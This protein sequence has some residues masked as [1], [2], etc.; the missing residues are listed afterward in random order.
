MNINIR[1]N[2]KGVFMKVIVKVFVF[3]F[4]LFFSSNLYAQEKLQTNAGIV[5]FYDSELFQWNYNIWNG[6]TLNYKNQNY[7]TLFG[8]PDAMKD[9][10]SLYDDAYKEYNIYNKKMIAGNIM[11]FCGLIAAL[12]GITYSIVGVNND[13]FNYNSAG[14]WIFWGGFTVELIG[15]LIRDDSTENLFNAARIFN[16][17]K[18]SEY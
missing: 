9:A 16:R 3:A 11:T 2:S 1:H 12:G 7:G 17:H 10:F 14:I 13:P 6:L 8:I 4:V 18:I 15:V 5:Q